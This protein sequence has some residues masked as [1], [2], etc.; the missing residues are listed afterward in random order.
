MQ[1]VVKALS[2]SG[3]SN[4]EI[5]EIIEIPKDENLGDYAFPCFILAKKLKKNPLE[6]AKEL[7]FLTVLKNFFTSPLKI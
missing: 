2:V 5:E 6:I 7:S 1:N 4:K 3:L